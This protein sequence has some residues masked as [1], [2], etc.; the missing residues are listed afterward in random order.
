M[1]E[2]TLAKRYSDEETE[3]RFAGRLLGEDAYDV[4]IQGEDTTV[5]KEDGEPLII[6]RA[7]VLKAVD[8]KAAYE[9]LREAATPTDNRGMAAGTEF[10]DENKGNARDIAVRSKTRYRPLKKDGTVSRTTYAKSVHSG[11]VGFFDRSSRNPYCRLTAYNLNEP[12][13]FA[14]AM[15]FIRSVD[16][17]FAENAPARY[18]AQRAVVEE[19]SPDFYIS[20]TVFTT[21]T[22]NLNWQT[23]VHKDA[24]DY[25]PGFGVMTALRAGRYDGCYLTWPQ[26]RVA[27]DLQSGDVILAD[28][29][30]W[31]GNTPFKTFEGEP[32][33]RLSLV[34]YY[35]EKMRE[36]GT[37]AEE[38]E[39]VQSLRYE[40]PKI[41]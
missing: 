25:K 28:V 4:L 12:E 9:N 39:R 33:E 38:L 1:R 37:A 27:A 18:A 15:P 32:Y 16:R 3:E 17:V 31:H 14:K 21:I 6:F 8:A 40:A 34:F 7:G 20:G 2:I 19:T 36:C 13:K 11:I 26:Y 23:A 22:V 5:Y 30:E 29:H 41:D 35:R 24:G 10:T